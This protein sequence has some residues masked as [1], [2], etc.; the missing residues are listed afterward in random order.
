MK[1]IIEYVNEK[2]NLPVVCISVADAED[3][4][5]FIKANKLEKDVD[6]TDWYLRLRQ[7]IA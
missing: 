4:V 3:I 2:Q 5:N 6:K 1:N 7:Q